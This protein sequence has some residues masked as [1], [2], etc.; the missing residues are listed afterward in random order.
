MICVCVCVCVC[1]CARVRACV[2]ARAKKFELTC[3]CKNNAPWTT[4]SSKTL[5]NKPRVSPSVTKD[6]VIFVTCG[7]CIEILC[8]SLS[9]NSALTCT[10]PQIS[11]LRVDGALLYCVKINQQE[12]QFSR[13]RTAYPSHALYQSKYTDSVLWKIEAGCFG[14]GVEFEQQSFPKVNGVA[15]NRLVQFCVMLVT[16]VLHIYKSP[17]NSK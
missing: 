13:Q 5:H 2:R 3:V 1:V 15:H 12:G 4:S 10:V 11:D 14:G 6:E 9:R 8:T 16:G 7:K 17:I